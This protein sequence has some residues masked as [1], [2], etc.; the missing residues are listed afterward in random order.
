MINFILI[1]R[2]GIAMK[3]IL[4]SFLLM[5]M[6]AG[7][8]QKPTN[9]EKPADVP[10]VEQEK[11]E[12]TEVVKKIDE[13]KDWVYYTN[14]DNAEY[15]DY[16]EDTLD[17]WLNVYVD[18]EKKGYPIVLN[19]DSEDADKYNNP[20]PT[21]DKDGN[22][23]DHFGVYNWRIYS[24]AHTWLISEQY[25]SILTKAISGGHY[26][27][28]ARTFSLTNGKELSNDELLE[29][30]GLTRNKASKIA[31]EAMKDRGCVSSLSYSGTDYQCLY[32]EETYYIDNFSIYI[33]DQSIL[34][35]D[36]DN[37]L[38]VILNIEDNN[39]NQTGLKLIVGLIETNDSS[40]DDKTVIDEDIEASDIDK[41][42]RIT[43]EPIDIQL[44]VDQYKDQLFIQEPTLLWDSEDAL[45]FNSKMSQLAQ[46]CRNELTYHD[47]G[48]WHTAS[49][50]NTKYYIN[51]DIL[52]I[53]VKLDR[54]L[55][56]AGVGPS[57]FMTYNFSLT[58]HKQLSNDEILEMYHVSP[59]ELQEGIN[60]QLEKDYLPCSAPVGEDGLIEKPCYG[61]Y[62]GSKGGKYGETS[63]IYI[64]DKM[65]HMYVNVHQAMYQ[66]NVDL[67]VYDLNEAGE[68]C[69]VPS[70]KETASNNELKSDYVKKIDESKDWVFINDIHASDMDYA[71]ID[72]KQ[73]ILDSEYKA[74]NEL[75]NWYNTIVTY[76][77]EIQ[78]FTIN[79]DSQEANRINSWIQEQVQLKLS[80]PKSKGEHVFKVKS[81]VNEEIL[82]VLI[83]SCLFLPGSGWNDE[84]Y[85]YNFDLATG[86]ALTNDELVERFELDNSQVKDILKHI[87]DENNQIA[88]D[89]PT[90]QQSCYNWQDYYV[91]DINRNYIF[92]VNG[93]LNILWQIHDEQGFGYYKQIV[94]V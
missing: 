62:A 91:N 76:T 79:I 6:I 52:S 1:K 23:I 64:K 72:M 27:W 9:V 30:Y 92:I 66:E 56:N 26:Q 29:I 81:F 59:I 74:G 78:N 28:G 49:L 8:V 10:M 3:K 35:V 38:N 36:E 57:E 2:Q 37:H 54:W 5:T 53:V 4:M 77:P 63:L 50:L 12:E 89:Y 61:E 19:I 67:M 73:M 45:Q 40:G 41:I 65:I 70:D 42:L 16:S 33:D 68:G 88:C 15:Y 18:S 32:D 24:S 48:Y 47:N 51:D 60:K 44:T 21:L 13:S 83:R 7:C 55:A 17:E 86:K 22:P 85:I 25:V 20:S 87:F 94:L 82:S 43:N 80:D 93:Q 34:Y 69:A 84:T 71:Y 11:P 75:E 39:R 90:S 31:E 46:T 58:T 14:T